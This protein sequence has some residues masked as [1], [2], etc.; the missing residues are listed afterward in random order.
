MTTKFT[1]TSGRPKRDA[2]YE[3]V[4]YVR[5]QTGVETKVS[6]AVI[7][8]WVQYVTEALLADRRVYMH[9]LGTFTLRHRKG[10]WK[11]KLR[12]NRGT[13]DVITTIVPDCHQISFR[14]SKP[15]KLKVNKPK[16]L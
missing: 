2:I 5:R 16:T 10:G 15:L 9:G 11:A 3:F 14:A 7:R 12:S 6:R 13:G 4:L 1:G 8:L